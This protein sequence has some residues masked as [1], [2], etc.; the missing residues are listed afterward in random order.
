M[1]LR[2]YQIEALQKINLW[3]NQKEFFEK[4]KTRGIV[5]AATG[6]G[7][8]VL[9]KHL[10]NIL[11]EPF[12]LIAHRKE[13]I[14]QL[15]EAIPTHIPPFPTGKTRAFAETIQTLS[16]HP[17]EVLN[18]LLSKFK[19]IV[20][21]EAHHSASKSYRRIIDKITPNQK[22]IGFTATPYRYDEEDLSFAYGEEPIFS[23]PLLQAIK[24]GYLVNIKAQR[25]N[26]EFNWAT[27][28]AKKEPSNTEVSEIYKYS[29]IIKGVH[30]AI[31]QAEKPA[32]IFLP[33]IE[34]AQI[35]YS[36]L[37]RKKVIV[38]HYKMKKSERTKIKQQIKDRKIDVILN[39]ELFTEG[40]DIPDIRS[41][42]IGRPTKS[43]VLYSQMIG[44]GTRLSQGAFHIDESK[45]KYCTIYEF[46]NSNEQR[47][48]LIQDIWSLIGLRPLKNKN[49]VDIL[50]ETKEIKRTLEEAIV[51]SIIEFDFFKI[52][53]RLPKADWLKIPTG[54]LIM[55]ISPPNQRSDLWII[56]KPNALGIAKVKRNGTII[57]KG[58]IKDCLRFC[59]KEMLKYP[60]WLWKKTKRK[61]WQYE[62]A[63]IK[64]QS[65]LRQ[66][67][68]N[69]KLTKLEAT[70]L[71]QLCISGTLK[72]LKEE[73]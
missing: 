55:Y 18:A 7:K 53:E 60:D 48:K 61:K 38:A 16:K 4:P 15:E 66:F 12:L 46:Q 17:D 51:K 19:T 1:K 3:F 43:P 13:L 57:H 9:I 49:Y 29:D 26:I 23:Y 71:T 58:N 41:I 22:L 65:L 36:E 39:V 67:G 30:E 64:Q 31:I 14:Q 42:I 32:L 52:N 56:T 35:I 59:D 33:T 50:K 34:A 25:I 68:I 44:R 40:I 70:R 27:I 5:Q 45:K 8:T 72:R 73:L 24:D 20:I 10:P 2:K 54:E 63:T 6:T 21:D 28:F 69:K 47:E 62:P 11:P 37:N